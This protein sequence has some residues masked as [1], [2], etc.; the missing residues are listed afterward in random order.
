MEGSAAASTGSATSG[1]SSGGSSASSSGGQSS[2]QSQPKSI[3]TNI[4]ASVGRQAATKQPPQQ[5]TFTPSEGDGETEGQ[6]SQHDPQQELLKQRLKLKVDGQE[7]ELPIEQIVK[8]YNLKQA[9][10]KRFEEAARLR[11]E[12]ETFYETLLTDPKAALSN[13]KLAEKGFNLRQLAENVL[14]EEIEREMLTPEQLEQKAKEREL[15]ELKTWK[16]QQEEQAQQERHAKAK[17]AA[18]AKYSTK[19]QEALE[20][21]KLPKNP[22]TLK[23][24]A[25]YQRQALRTGYDLTASELGDLVREEATNDLKALTSHLDAESLLSLLGDDIAKK[26]REHDLKRVTQPSA[27]PQQ[28]HSHALKSR[29]G[30]AEKKMSIQ[31]WQELRRKQYGV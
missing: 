30:G 20:V 26:I 31:E 23:R 8:D 9:S 27:V 17:Q 11:K 14:K 1:Q 24:M 19:F 15:E 25:E 7:M 21:A 3:G 28:I 10:M 2:G 18:E 6:T 29:S 13:P 22:F 4:P 5:Q 12:A 16:Q